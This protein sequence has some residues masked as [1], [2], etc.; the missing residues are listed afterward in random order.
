MFCA[1]ALE[2]FDGQC[3]VQTLAPAREAANPA[4][5][6]ST[7]VKDHYDFVWRT[8]RHLGLG[9]APAEDGAQQVMCVLARRFDEELPGAER[10]FLFS[11]AIRVASTLRRSAKR[12]PESTGVEFESIAEPAQDIEG[13]LD[14]RRGY[15]VLQG[16]LDAMPLELRVVF[17][18]YELEEFTVPEV[19]TTLAIPLGTATSRLRRAR[20]EFQARVRRLQATRRVGRELAG[21]QGDG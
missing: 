11:T 8:L 14:D 21:R 13:M 19:A 12:H 16:V 9:A 10:A 5:R 6:L 3:G 15:E 1:R 2:N 18:L 20:D 17:V 4:A 7:L